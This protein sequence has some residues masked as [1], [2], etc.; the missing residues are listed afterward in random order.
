[1]DGAIG[2]GRAAVAEQLRM[3]MMMACGRS[4]ERERERGREGEREGV[5]ETCP[6]KKRPKAFAASTTE[7]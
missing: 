5:S 3:M 6:A 1:M 2:W 4:F 7:R